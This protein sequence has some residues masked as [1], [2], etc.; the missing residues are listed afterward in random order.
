LT[1]VYHKYIYVRTKEEK[2]RVKKY[3]IQFCDFCTLFNTLRGILFLSNLETKFFNF[4]FCS[5]QL[6][7]RNILRDFEA[8][9]IKGHFLSSSVLLK[10]LWKYRDVK[11]ARLKYPLSTSYYKV[12]LKKM[13]I[14]NVKNVQGMLSLSL[15]LL[16][17]FSFS[18]S[19]N[20]KHKSA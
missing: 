15:S 7:L 20:G 5:R 12:L 2:E 6:Y 10:V 4:Q 11:L 1:I 14:T 8:S 17:S 18:R 9:F 13:A 19:T 3:I 16:F